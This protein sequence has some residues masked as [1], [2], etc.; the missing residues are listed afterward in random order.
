[1]YRHFLYTF[2]V[3][4]VLLLPNHMM[5]AAGGS[6]ASDQTLTSGLMSYWTLDEEGGVRL[7]SH[8]QNNLLDTNLVGFDVGVQESAALF[9]R[10]VNTRLT[11]LSDGGIANGAMSWSVWV[12]PTQEIALGNTECFTSVFDVNTHV[13]YDL[14]YDNSTGTKQILFTRALPG[15]T[16]HSVFY[17]IGNTQSIWHHFVLTYSQSVTKAYINGV[18]VGSVAASGSGAVSGID[19]ITIGSRLW[20]NDHYTN[21]IIDEVGLWNRAL[22]QDEVTRLYNDGLGLPYILPNHP[23][24]LSPIGNKVVSEGQTL[25]FVATSTDP[26]GDT[27]TY[28][29]TNLPPGALFDAATGAF[30]WTPDF[31]QAGS[32]TVTLAASDDG[33]PSMSVSESIVITVD[34]TNRTPILN[35][36]GNKQVEEGQLLTFTLV[37]TDPDGDTLT[38]SALNLPSGASLHPTTG[39][40]TWT[41]SYTQ[42]DNYMDVELTVTDSGS[43]IGV[44]SELITITVGNINRPAEFT[45]DATYEVPEG[46]AL[47][48]VLTAVDPDGDALMYS[49]GTLPAG[50]S[51][52][53]S[54]AT[55][56][57]T[58]TTSQA[59]VYPIT[60][61]AIDNGDPAISVPHE[62]TVTVGNVPTPIELSDA[63]VADVIALNLP[64]N[65]ENSYLG[66]LKKVSGL[67]EEGKISN[68][69]QK[70]E[71]FIEKVEQDITQN[72][73]TSAVGLPLIAQAQALI[74]Q[75]Q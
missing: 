70:L 13:G 5:Y 18:F 8:G 54:T 15:V 47:S 23:P 31:T 72:K 38:Y 20:E 42:S 45:S 55:F 32:Y 73:I 2:L 75:L 4:S 39:T 51:F 3:S 37:A 50:A 56:S 60:F 29:A 30:V 25:S 52:N 19:N 67:I 48:F 44:A 62:V 27:L 40:F 41:P 10:S 46:Q 59:G 34:P 7:D 35:T 12:K 49:V 71:D 16:S 64:R 69:I 68:A 58:P 61:T 65:I 28:S 26:D 33:T 6:V 74:A 14:C 17:P 21:A 1:M 9:S 11:A 53:A 57:W 43:P 66:K 63:L 36:I 24:V 22:T